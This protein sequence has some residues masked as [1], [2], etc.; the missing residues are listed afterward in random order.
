MILAGL[1]S[2]IRHEGN[3]EPHDH[4]S[5]PSLIRRIQKEQK[6]SERKPDQ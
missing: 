6:A 3:A 2:S 5:Y 4:G 1:T